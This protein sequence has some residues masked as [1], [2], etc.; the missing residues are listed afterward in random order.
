VILYR[1]ELDDDGIW[2]L[3]PVGLWGLDTIVTSVYFGPLPA[4]VCVEAW[5]GFSTKSEGGL[6][7]LDTLFTCVDPQDPGDVVEGDMQVRPG[8]WSHRSRGGWVTVHLHLPSNVDAEDVDPSTV[9]LEGLPVAPGRM[10]HGAGGPDWT[11]RVDRRA[12][13]ALLGPGTHSVELQG[14]IGAGTFTATD[15]LTIR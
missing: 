7:V 4:R 13:T 8:Q 14:T 3:P 9:T 1:W 11:F 6:I 15:V 2:D 12:L 10:G 5:D